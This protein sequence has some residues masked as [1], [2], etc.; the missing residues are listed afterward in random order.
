MERLHNMDFFFFNVY[1]VWIFAFKIAENA[2]TSE[3]ELQK[4]TN[5]E[6]WKIGVPLK[7]IFILSGNC[8]VKLEL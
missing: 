7:P 6:K 5:L 1:W 4:N 2:F 3:N 8:F